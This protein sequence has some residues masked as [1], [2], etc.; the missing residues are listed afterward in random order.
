MQTQPL[1]EPQRNE[2]VPF[3]ETAFDW[4]LLGS[5]LR[6]RARLLIITTLALW[7]GL[8]LLCLLFVPRSFS[9]TASVALQ[10]S[11]SPG[12]ALGAIAGLSGSSTKTYAGVIRSRRFALAAARATH[13]QALYNLPK[14]DDAAALVQNGVTMEDKQDGLIYLTVNLPA[15]PKFALGKITDV[16]KIQEAAPAVA[17]AYVKLLA[18]YLDTTNTNRDAALIREA[19]KQV[20][21]A[22]TSYDRSIQDLDRVVQ[23]SPSSAALSAPS[24]S[25]SQT[26]LN[27]GAAN[28]TGGAGAMNQLSAL[29]AAK[30]RL[31]TEIAAGNALRQGTAALA[32]GSTQSL[33][34]LPGEDPLLQDARRQVTQ[35]TT[36]LQSLRI[37]LSDD[38][39]DVV[40]ARRR[41]QIAQAQ[42]RSESKALEQGRTSDSIRQQSLEAQYLTVLRQIAAAERSNVTGRSTTLEIEKQSNE[43]ML[44]LEVL[45]AT[46]T[47]SAALAIQRGAGNNL[48]DIID[49]PQTPKSGK[50]GAAIL[51]ILCFF[52]ALF[53]VQLGLGLEYSVRWYQQS[54]IAK[55]NLLASSNERSGS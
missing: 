35:A 11:P 53:V 50:P 4:S 42:L 33:T 30:A 39:P 31:E 5:I 43:V 14:E 27:S 24:M 16:R 23:G 52:I 18:H 32:S 20:A 41:L 46:A 1:Q 54:A 19:Q 37:T 40:A 6:Q 34:A 12:G 13:I 21:K 51:A 45:K 10:Q 26:S 38:N 44:R 7:V 8:T 36:Q 15:P 22:R 2:L 25:S 47:Q 49:M 55:A 3:Q 28:G 48:M 9:A 29:Y 17:V